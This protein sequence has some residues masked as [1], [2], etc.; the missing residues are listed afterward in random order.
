MMCVACWIVW[1]A[2][3]LVNL[4]HLVQQSNGDLVLVSW[5]TV[6]NEFDTK[7]IWLSIVLLSLNRPPLCV[8]MSLKKKNKL[9]NVC[10]YLY[11]LWMKFHNYPNWDLHENHFIVVSL[12]NNEFIYLRYHIFCKLFYWN[13]YVYYF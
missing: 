1:A 13:L 5:T 9:V 4:C 2:A 3:W 7:L 10:V 6:D 12:T 11:W 8:N